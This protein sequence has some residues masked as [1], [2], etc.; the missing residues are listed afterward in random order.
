[1]HSPEA[2]RVGLVTREGQNDVVTVS[3]LLIYI[4]SQVDD[5]TSKQSIAY[6]EKAMPLKKLGSVRKHI[7]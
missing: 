1:V 4:K 3:G 6:M 7:E 2:V 5:F